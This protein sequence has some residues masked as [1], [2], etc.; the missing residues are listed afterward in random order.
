VGV[1]REAMKMKSAMLPT[2][3]KNVPTRLRGSIRPAGN[4]NSQ[5]G[6][7]RLGAGVLR[8]YRAFSTRV[9]I[10]SCM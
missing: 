1:K 5:H 9:R 8:P 3:M 7:S 4:P 2:N 10:C 6:R